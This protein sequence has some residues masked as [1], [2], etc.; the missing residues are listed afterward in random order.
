MCRDHAEGAEGEKIV[1]AKSAKGSKRLWM[2]GTLA[3]NGDF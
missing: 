2:L 1:N 3:P